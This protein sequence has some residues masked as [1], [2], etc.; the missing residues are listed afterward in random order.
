MSFND[1]QKY[2]LPIIDEITNPSP[3]PISKE[4]CE[5]IYNDLNGCTNTVNK[6]TKTPED[7]KK[8]IN[9]I[10]QMEGGDFLI[11]VIYLYIH[12]YSNS[13]NILESC[14]KK[15]PITNILISLINLISQM[16]VGIEEINKIMLKIC[17]NDSCEPDLYKGPLPNLNLNINEIIDNIKYTQILKRKVLIGA[18]IALIIIV[19]LVSVLIFLGIKLR[20]NK[21][22]LCEL[23]YLFCLIITA[24]I[25]CIIL[26]KKFI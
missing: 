26:V 8:F 19:I 20:K 24:L 22:T 25:F 17:K 11:K 12:Q 1:I 21:F 7:M 14:G 4:L 2:C 13:V 10:Y 18:I 16:D 6:I 15:T 3:S 9:D 5:K 23:I